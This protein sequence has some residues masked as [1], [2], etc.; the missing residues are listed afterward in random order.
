MCL[1]GEFFQ[2]G[3]SKRYYEISTRSDDDLETVFKG[4][5]K[6]NLNYG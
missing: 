2:E 5:E 6:S 4:E 3:M 1:K